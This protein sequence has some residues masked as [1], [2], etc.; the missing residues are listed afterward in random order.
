MWTDLPS[1]TLGASFLAAAVVIFFSGLRITT[2]ADRLADRT[3]L[4]EALVG[5]V[6]LGAATSLSGTVVSITSALDGRASLAFA[7]SVGGIAAQ[8]VFLAIADMVYRK[9]NLEHAAADLSNI[10]Q[11]VVLIG[12]LSLPLVALTTP[13]IS[14]WAVHPVSL[15]IPLIYVAGLASGQSVRDNPMWR[16]VNTT[17]TRADIPEREDAASRKQSTT[18]LFITFGALMVLMGVA[19]WVIAR[20]AGVLT[21]RMDVSETLVGALITAIVTSMPE[22]VTTVAAVRRGALQ[23]AVGGIIGGNTFDV[24]FLTAADISYRDGS[25]YHA[26]GTNDYFWLVT[27][28]LMTAVLIAGLILRQRLGPGR[29]GGES[30]AL[31]LLYVGAIAVQAMIAG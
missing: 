1:L 15:A 5:A 6:L 16:A 9:A 11:G 2:L 20:S 4:G 30:I 8:T 21:D 17:S 26:V 27:A 25:L 29:I 7:N 24:L 28:M 12:L 22:L 31:I 18:R 14:I 19:G 10:Y 3:G 13:E 23:L